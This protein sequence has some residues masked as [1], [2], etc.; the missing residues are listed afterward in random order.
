MSRTGIL[1]GLGVGPGDPELMTVKAWRLLSTAPVIAYPRPLE[2]ESLARRI[3]ALFIP[4]EAIEL[5]VTIP[6]RSERA[7]ARAAYDAGAAAIARHLVEGRDVAF[8]CEGDPLFY[9]SFIYLLERLGREYETVVVPGV[10]SLTASAAVL[11]RPLATR[12]DVLKVIPAT[13]GEAR[14]EAELS[15]A[16]AAAVIKVGR[17]FDM[18]RAVI[19]RLGLAGRATVVEAATSPDQKLTPLSAMPAG[20]C[21]YFSTI[22][23]H[24]AGEP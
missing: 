5:E 13:A 15:T 2:G 21:P 14:L 6:M 20:A 19:E 9:G 7:P 12:S 11:A 18:V 3:A 8:L 16:E 24:R 22:L 1:Y 4:E 10:T 23:V 17:H